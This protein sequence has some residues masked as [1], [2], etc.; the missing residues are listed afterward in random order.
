MLLLDKTAVVTG[1]NKGI[2]KSIL[3]EFSKNGANIFACVRKL[4]D[5]FHLLIK[6]LEKKN[7]N[8]IFPIEID[9]SDEGSVKK[10]AKEILSSE[11]D[12]D[13]LIN[14][15][16]SISSSIFQMTSTAKYKELFDINFHSQVLLTQFM[17]KSMMKNKNGNIVFISSSSGIDGNEGRSAYVSTKAAII[18]Q[19]KVLSREVGRYNIKVNIIAPGLTNTDMMKKNT[20]EKIIDEVVSKL[21]LKRVGEP[22]EVANVALFLSSN[23]SDYITGQ[24]IRV[25]GGM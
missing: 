1:C 15:A 11:L 2:G 21:S 3:E 4:D 6:E 20:P 5:K 8:K 10:G 7:N 13:I 24:V 17:L 9:L 18:G 23:L 22:N 12:I 19:A 16:A 14:N 25:D